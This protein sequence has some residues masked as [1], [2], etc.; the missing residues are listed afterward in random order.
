MLVQLWSAQK[1][2]E[3]PATYP[4]V[5][6]FGCEQTWSPLPSEP[7][8]T[9][10]RRTAA[11]VS[12]LVGRP[13]GWPKPEAV[14]EWALDAPRAAW[15]GSGWERPLSLATG[16]R[17][18]TVRWERTESPAPAVLQEPNGLPLLSG[19]GR[20]DEALLSRERA[21]WRWYL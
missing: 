10:L 15:P 2:V 17:F 8:G 18:E 4:T 12:S 13:T 9:P 5:E 3:Q 19:I 21:P 20:S 11:N 1:A 7:P 16:S 14:S 6:D